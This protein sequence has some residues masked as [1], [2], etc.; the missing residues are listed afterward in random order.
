[1]KKLL[2]PTFDKPNR[3]LAVV[4]TVTPWNEISRI[5]HQVTRQLTRFYNVLYIEL[6]FGSNSRTDQCQRVNDNLILFKPKRLLRGLGRVFDNLP[7]FHRAYNTRL[8]R[9]VESLIRELQYE[10]AVL[11]N[12]QFNFSQI[13]NSDMFEK[14]IY[15][16]NDEFPDTASTSRRRRLFRRY[17]GD[18]I[19]NADVCLCVSEPLAE[20]IRRQGRNV[21]VFFPGHEFRVNPQDDMRRLVRKTDDPI[22]VCFMGYI[23]DRI[24]FDWLEQLLSDSNVEL[25]LIGP[26]QEQDKVIS[27]QRFRNLTVL[28]PC[29]GT[30]LRNLM[31]GNDVLLMPYDTSQHFSRLTSAPNKLFQYLACGRPIVISDMERFVDLPQGFI[32]R[33]STAEQ[34]VEAV[35]RAF[36]EDS[37]SATFARL[38][39]ASENTWD[40]R[41]DLLHAILRSDS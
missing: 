15:L 41:G 10:H 35:H 30:R 19:E 12:F 6:P 11:V 22:R 1:M 26:V 21:R 31:M 24:R 13:M 32:Y 7:S 16:C 40:V 36:D 34:F 2:P 28:A 29:E 37:E 3:A 23:N 38:S 5:R 9:K 18:V 27:L 20:K 8:T 4:T 14:T 33:A 25:S 39:Y 17:E